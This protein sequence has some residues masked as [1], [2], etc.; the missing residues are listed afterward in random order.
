MAR[1]QKNWWACHED[2]LMGGGAAIL[3][4][5]AVVGRDFFRE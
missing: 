5:Y 4:F 2:C 3:S 1:I